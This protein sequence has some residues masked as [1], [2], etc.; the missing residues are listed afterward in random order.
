MK[1]VLYVLGALVGLAIL[2]FLSEVIAS[3]SGEVVVL[4]TQSQEGP[5]ETR[6]WVVDLDGVQHLRAGTDSGWYQ[7]LLAAPDVRVSRSGAAAA[8]RAE[9]N[10][11]STEAVNRLM[12]EKYGWRDAYISM[13]IGG[14]EDSIAVALLPPG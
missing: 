10:P 6:L 8:Y 12:R 14:R 9:P 13:L 4:T 3:E 2:I 1:L 11:A 5:K 7:R